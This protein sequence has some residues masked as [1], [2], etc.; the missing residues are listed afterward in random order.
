MLAEY[1]EN[2][3]KDTQNLIQN[4]KN[5]TVLHNNSNILKNSTSVKQKPP[6]G[7]KGF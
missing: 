7:P 5:S 3:T 6:V 4:K 1:R 2:K